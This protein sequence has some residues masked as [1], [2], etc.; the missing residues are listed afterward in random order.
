MILRRHHQA[1]LGETFDRSDA[2]LAQHGAPLPHLCLP[3][4]PIALSLCKLRLRSLR[5]MVTKWLPGLARF[6]NILWID[7]RTHHMGELIEF[8][9]N[10]VALTVGVRTQ[11]LLRRQLEF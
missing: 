3:V 5:V 4:A 10:P 8:N 1:E 11:L 9:M 2:L 6:M 7:S